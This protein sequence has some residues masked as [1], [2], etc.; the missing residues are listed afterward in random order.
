MDMKI[1]ISY[2]RNDSGRDVGRIRDKLKTEF[3][4]QS[5]FRDLVD[6]PAG[7]DFPSYLNEKTNECK[8]ML[9]VIGPIW[10][11]ITGA[12]GN[13]RLFDPIDFTRMEVEAGLKRLKN[14]DVAVIPVFVGGARMPA[15]E[16]IPESI[17]SL[18]NQNGITINDDP[19]FDFDMERLISD[20]RKLEAV[21][22]VARSPGEPYVPK[23]LCIP[24]GPF[25]MG[26]QPGD[27][28]PEYETPQHEVNIPSY[29]IGEFPVKNSEYKEFV[30]QSGKLVPGIMGWDGQSFRDGQGDLPVWGITWNEAM[31]YCD[32][33]SR[34]TGRLYTLPNEAQWEK[35][36]RGS[37]GCGDSMGR[38]LEW[39]CTLWGERR[40][41]PDTKYKYPWKN[42]DRNNV[43]AHSQIRRVVRG[44][45]NPDETGMRRFSA[46]YGRNVLDTGEGDARHGFRVILMA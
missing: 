6:I 43:K 42:D 18:T 45:A 40:I 31:Q 29:Y 20:I 34:A 32:W 10:A 35:A 16:E 26:S 36:C 1:F 27:G 46:R 24:G 21:D 9:V 33:L 3:G 19:Y 12:N 44:Y 25:L 15:P 41:A 38:V 5:V 13:K 7:V 11:T 8:V 2:R 39:T 22:K 37:Y 28:I 23:T 14:K 4:E 30:V 17:V